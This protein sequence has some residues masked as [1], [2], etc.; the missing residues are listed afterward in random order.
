[1]F[2]CFENCKK[3][4]VASVIPVVFCKPKVI[5]NFIKKS[6]VFFV[7]EIFLTNKKCEKK[8]ESEFSRVKF[9]QS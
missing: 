8:E 3:K 6:V 5:T 7:E 1:M 9:S 2:C 4:K